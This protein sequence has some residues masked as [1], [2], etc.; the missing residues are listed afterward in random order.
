M[1]MA[2]ATMAAVIMGE[3]GDAIVGSAYY[4]TGCEPR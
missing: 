1:V 2:V 3:D 4:G